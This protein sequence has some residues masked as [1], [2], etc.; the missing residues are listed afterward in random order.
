M[1]IQGISGLPSTSLACCTQE[2]LESYP[3]N[4]AGEQRNTVLQ[5]TVLYRF[6]MIKLYYIKLY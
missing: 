5:T 4:A 1:L 2:W 6:N 3:T